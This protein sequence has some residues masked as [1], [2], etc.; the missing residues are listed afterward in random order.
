MNEIV[1]KESAIVV[2]GVEARAFGV[3]VDSKTGRI[4]NQR[5]GASRYYRENGHEFRISVEMRFDDE[6]NNGHETFAITADIRMDGREYMGGCCHDEIAQRFPEF[7]P[8]IKWHLTSTDGPMHYPGNALYFAGN[9]DCW[10]KLKGEPRSWSQAVRFGDSPIT[11]TLSDSFAHFLKLKYE[12]DRAFIVKPIEHKREPAGSYKFE[13]K[14]TFDGYAKEWH[15][16]PFDSLDEANEWRDALARCKV[17][18]ITI[19]TSW[20]EGKER[21][22]DKAR[23]VAVWPEATDEELSQEPEKLKAALLQRLPPLMARF[24][25][26]METAGFMWPARHDDVEEA[27]NRR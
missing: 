22:F 5:I 18:F 25:H 26:D 4:R 14:Y 10:G 19:P 6:L 1:R 12:G 7:E 21:E 9:R 16:C 24:R 15:E 8:L 23:N 17:E 20:G 11:H 27:V 13:P 3:V 2:N